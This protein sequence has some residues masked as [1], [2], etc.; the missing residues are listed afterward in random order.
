M[1]RTKKILTVTV[2][3]LISAFVLY[4]GIAIINCEYMTY[5]YGQQFE[6]AYIGHTMFQKP[7]YHKVIH[8]TETTAKVY[9]AN[10]GKGGD[11]VYY[12][13]ENP[14]SEWTFVKWITVWSAS[15]SADDFIWPYIR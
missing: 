9:Y 8:Y 14:D 5:R 2:V 11:V 1:K 7:D 15:G 6:D 13:R 10:Y 3:L 12:E 4:W